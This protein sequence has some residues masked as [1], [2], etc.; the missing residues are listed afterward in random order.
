[1]VL[2]KQMLY[3]G[4][5]DGTTLPYTSATNWNSTRAETNHAITKLGD[6]QQVSDQNTFNCI[7]YMR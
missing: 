7:R 2:P 4:E 3:L 1:M 5:N 6:N